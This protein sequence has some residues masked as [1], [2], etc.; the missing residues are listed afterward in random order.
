MQS[1]PTPFRRLIFVW[2]GA[3]AVGSLLSACDD[4]DE[5]SP[6]ATVDAGSD[7][8]TRTV[9]PMP[10]I[11]NRVSEAE[12]GAGRAGCRFGRG[13]MPWET[14]GEEFPLGD[15]IP[16]DTFVFVMQENRSFDH[17]F[18]MMPGVDGL[19]L[20]AMNLDT[21]GNPVTPFHTD[22]YCIEDVAHNWT[23]THLQFAGGAMDG[24][25]T[26]NDPD[27]GRAMGYLTEA[28]LP[29]YYDLYS[30]FAMSDQHFSSLLGSTWINRFYFMSG[31]SFGLTSNEPAPEFEFPM[32]EDYVVMQ[33]LDRRGIDWRVYKSDIPFVLGG[34]GLYSSFN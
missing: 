18:G 26:T 6:D 34:Y 23:N 19:P 13:A 8:A 15:D 7:A 32:D 28:D 25:V 20:D 9:E 10:E 14:V 31:T 16:I 24:F 27:G 29:Y 12:A 1:P 4:S 3:L 21:D 33:Q 30:T 5:T 22:D 2:M 17:Y 11:P